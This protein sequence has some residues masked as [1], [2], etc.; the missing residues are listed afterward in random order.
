M[1]QFSKKPNEIHWLPMDITKI[2]LSTTHLTKVNDLK[3]LS[4]LS[5][6]THWTQA[7]Y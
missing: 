1:Y 7:S 3:H 4:Q 5:H 2:P 6:G